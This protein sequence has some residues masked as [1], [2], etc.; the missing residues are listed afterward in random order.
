MASS[1]ASDAAPI[2]SKSLR[3]TPRYVVSSHEVHGDDGGGNESLNGGGNKGDVG[4]SAGVEGTVGAGNPG[5]G[6]EGERNTGQGE[7]GVGGGAKISTTEGSAGIA[8]LSTLALRAA[9]AVTGSC[10]GRSALITWFA[11]SASRV[12]IVAVTMRLPPT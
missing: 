7:P 11:A 5:G 12:R 3:G 1:N 9:E 4:V 6:A 8:K 10:S 2:K